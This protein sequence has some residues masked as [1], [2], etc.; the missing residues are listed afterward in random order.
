MLKFF[1]ISPMCYTSASATEKTGKPFMRQWFLFCCDFA[2]TKDQ[3]CRFFRDHDRGRV[4][5]A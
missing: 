2:A 5:V 4:G 3:I 1:K